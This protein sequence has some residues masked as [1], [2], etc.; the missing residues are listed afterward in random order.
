MYGI[1]YDNKTVMILKGKFYWLTIRPPMFYVCNVGQ[2]RNNMSLAKL[3]MLRWMSGNMLRDWI[4]NECISNKL[5]SAPIKD[6][7]REYM[8]CA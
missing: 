6:K 4:R 1:L 8:I 7:M 2:L 5:K 3:G